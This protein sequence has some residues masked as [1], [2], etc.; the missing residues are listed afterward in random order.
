M[1][2]DTKRR[3]GGACDLCGG[4]FPKARLDVQP[5]QDL[6]IFGRA[7]FTKRLGM[8]TQE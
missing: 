3:D 2:N 5:Y 6:V 7:R 4:S 1:N 8:I